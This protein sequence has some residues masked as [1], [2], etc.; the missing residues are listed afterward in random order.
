MLAIN[1]SGEGG[2]G[3]GGQRRR[4]TIPGHTHVV[5][6]WWGDASPPPL[7][8]NVSVPRP[9]QL[10]PVEELGE[11]G[12]GE[13]GVMRPMY[14]AVLCFAGKVWG[15]RVDNGSMWPSLY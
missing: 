12:R 14:I 2:G 10:H 1:K 11:R 15:S 6:Q 7:P 3:E 5:G 8:F 13:G 9:L 4:K